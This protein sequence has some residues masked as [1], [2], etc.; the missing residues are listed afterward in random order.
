MKSLLLLITCILIPVFIVGAFFRSNGLSQRFQAHQHSMNLKNSYLIAYQGGSKEAPANTWQ[1]IDKTLKLSKDIIIW[2]DVQQT[3][4]DKLVL[5][6]HDY[7]EKQSSGK[8]HIGFSTWNQI[9]DLDLGQGTRIQLLV[10]TL[11]RYPEAGFVI[12]VLANSKK[13]D[14]LVS[15]VINQTKSSNRVIINSPISIVIE[16]IKKKNPQWMFAVSLPEWT[17]LSMFHSLFLGPAIPI[18]GDILLHSR[19]RYQKLMDRGLL[20]ELHRRKRKVIVWAT[21]KEQWE[22]WKDLGADGVL[23]SDPSLFIQAN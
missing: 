1:A 3:K 21:E 17:R 22:K 7:L 20:E 11:N 5:F 13:I 4:D 15:D 10:D 12:N 6:G 18:K 16:S 23:T 19:I 14:L 9:K 8:G 2:L